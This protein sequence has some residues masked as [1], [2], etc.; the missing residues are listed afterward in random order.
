MRIPSNKNICIAV[1]GIIVAL[2]IFRGGASPEQLRAEA[3]E[4]RIKAMTHDCKTISKRV[5]DCFTSKTIVLRCR[6]PMPG[7]RMNTDGHLT[8][9]V[10]QNQ[11][12]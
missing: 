5:S 11:T 4:A 1:L 7:S 12:L 8:S 9:S 10:P 3:A 2:F 6:N